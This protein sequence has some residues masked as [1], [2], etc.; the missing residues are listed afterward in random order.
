MKKINNAAIK[1]LLMEIK[2]QLND[3]EQ[4]EIENGVWTYKLEL[5]KEDIICKIYDEDN[6]EYIMQI[7]KA[8]N[9]TDILKGFI[10]YLYE[11]EL[12]HRQAFLKANKGYYSRKHK[13]LNTWFLRDNR[14]KIDAIVEDLSERYSIS[15]KVE[16]EITHY[17]SF[18]SDM[19]SCLNCLEP[20]WKTADIKESIFKK[21]EEFNIKN[22][23]VTYIENT[24]IVMK[25]DEKAENII[26]KFDIVVDSYSNKSAIVNEAINRLRKGMVA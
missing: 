15:K 21:V 4:W 25:S 3:R 9:V 5:K 10:S 19:Y 6:I 24:I 14:A 13:S 17:K 2:G 1:K 22:V 8:D 26:D 23:G 16:F 7:E 18:V 12:N 20:S 11:N